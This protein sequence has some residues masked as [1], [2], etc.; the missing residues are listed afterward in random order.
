M[1]DGLEIV[2]R[3][4]LNI[5][6]AIVRSDARPAQQLLGNCAI[7]CIVNSFIHFVRVHTA[8]VLVSTHSSVRSSATSVVP[9]FIVRL[10]CPFV[11]KTVPRTRSNTRSKPF[12]LLV[13]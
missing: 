7:D 2:M 3:H 1:I 9:S 10:S 8:T 5:V 11:V 12:S 6:I 4:A 13:R